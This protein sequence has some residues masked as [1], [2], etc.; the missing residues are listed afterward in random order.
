MSNPRLPS[1]AASWEQLA[2]AI[3]KSELKMAG[4]NY[5][6]LQS[7][8]RT[9]GIEQTTNNIS[10]K[11]NQGRFSAVFLMQALVAIGVERIELPLRNGRSFNRDGVKD[12]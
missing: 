5:I 3:V 11:L 4:M 1:D 2:G 7:A 9:L 12:R 8:L 6:D 10:A